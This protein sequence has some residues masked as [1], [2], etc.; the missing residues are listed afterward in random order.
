MDL[1]SNVL[2]WITSPSNDNSTIK[3]WA[4]GLIA[5]LVASFLWSEVID[6]IGEI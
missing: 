6:S 5:I 4:L 1:F 2:G 3:F